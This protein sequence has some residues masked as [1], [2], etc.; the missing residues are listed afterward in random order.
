[1]PDFEAT[2][3]LMSD[4]NRFSEELE[5]Y[6]QAGAKLWTRAEVAR[7]DQ[8]GLRNRF[9]PLI[10]EAEAQGRIRDW[11]MA[12]AAAAHPDAPVFGRR[13]M[14]RLKT[15]PGYEQWKD[16][17]NRAEAEGRIYDD[18]DPAAAAL[19]AERDD[20]LDLLLESRQALARLIEA[21]LDD[22]RP[23]AEG[24]RR[25]L[26]AGLD[27]L[28]RPELVRRYGR[29]TLPLTPETLPADL[30]AVKQAVERW[31]MWRPIA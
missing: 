27:R 28:N 14:D 24:E 18:V 23:L 13:Q 21:D 10:D 30:D 16:W 31:L 7:L 5:L 29:L 11:T 4:Y 12:E 20:Y 17:L 9:R 6:R 26:T 25:E 15:G 1:M 19:L 3:K 8:L 22:G 2:V